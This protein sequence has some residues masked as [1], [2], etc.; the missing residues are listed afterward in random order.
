MT[1]MAAKMDSMRA[2]DRWVRLAPIL[3]LLLTAFAYLPSLGGGFLN[4]DDPWLLES[5]RMFQHPSWRA[6]WAIWS[7]FSLPCRL[8]FGAE[9]L[10]LRD[11]SHLVEAW[12]TGI[13]PLPLRVVNLSLYLGAIVVVHRLLRT[14]LE[15]ALSALVVTAVFA[16]HPVHV[17]SVAWIAGRKDL[18][19]M[20]FA[21]LA[22]HAYA[23]RRS[24]A[25]LW[26]PFWFLLA[27]LSKSMSVALPLL[28]PLFDIWGKRRPNFRVIG[29]SLLLVAAV[30]PVHVYVG[31]L[32]GM[33]QPHESGGTL[34]VLATMGPVWLRYIG[35]L[36]WPLNCSLIHEVPTN[37]GWGLVPVLGNLLLVVAAALAV[38]QWRA[39]RPQLLL[40]LGFFL[41]PLLPV[42]QLIAELQNKM[43]DRYLWWS[44]LALGVMLLQL[45][46]CWP[47][48]GALV[49][50]IFLGFCLAVTAER[51][52]LFGNSALVFADASRKTS[53][54]GIAPYQLAM[55]LEAQGDIEPARSAFEEVWRRTQGKDD[56]ARRATNNLARLEARE[57][58]L[59]RA[60]WVLQ[61]GLRYFPNDPVMQ[62]NLSK[63]KAK[64]LAAQHQ[65][66]LDRAADSRQDP[67][68]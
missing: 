66:D 8:R 38:Q 29:A 14:V 36:L 32:V 33:T 40:I 1:D 30:M 25:L 39:K 26:T 48:L 65:T 19:A 57:G 45:I 16:L 46:Q 61:R 28:L 3:L 58:N 42:S 56:T 54:S 55:A 27:M 18:L 5:N 23:A 13:L 2:S 37:N 53:H 31:H 22:M 62:G 44:V 64:Q 47:R 35:V 24:Q 4:M 15:A 68:N 52:S 34:R 12:L 67:Q 9:Y 50:L 63:V 59:E 60:R 6:L 10:P 43:A 41:V 51:A 21:A 17:E 20:L 49:V 11:T 7:D